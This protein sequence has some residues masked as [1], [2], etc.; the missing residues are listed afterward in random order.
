VQADLPTLRYQKHQ[1]LMRLDEKS[2]TIRQQQDEIASLKSTGNSFERR[3]FELLA[4]DKNAFERQIG[5]LTR[6]IDEVRPHLKPRSWLASRAMGS[7]VRYRRPTRS[8]TCTP[9]GCS[10]SSRP[11]SRC[12]RVCALLNHCSSPRLRRSSHLISRRGFARHRAGQGAV[13]RG[14]DGAFGRDRAGGGGRG[15]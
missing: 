10:W 11:T 14:A 13:V 4:G 3:S 1:I 5:I 15:R 9:S 2:Q 8:C 12:L 6:I 7:C